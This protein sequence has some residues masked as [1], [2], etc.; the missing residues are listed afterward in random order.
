MPL[1][2]TIQSTYYLLNIPVDVMFF[3]SIEKAKCNNLF[4]FKK[5]CLRLDQLLILSAETLCR[6]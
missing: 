6:L 4:V 5:L 3:V 2:I 1:L